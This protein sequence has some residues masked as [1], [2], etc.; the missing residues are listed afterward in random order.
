[1]VL[2]MTGCGVRQG[3]KVY[4][5]QCGESLMCQV[6]TYRS[7]S[8]LWGAHKS[9]PWEVDQAGYT[10]WMGVM[11]KGQEWRKIV[12]LG[13]HCNRPAECFLKECQDSAYSYK[14]PSSL[15]NSS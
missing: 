5:N 15:E 4:T 11:G 8:R 10:W 9:Y 2:D 3:G 6:K 7:F 1:M 14:P 12:Q 13:G